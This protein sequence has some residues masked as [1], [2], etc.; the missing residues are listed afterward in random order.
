MGNIKINGD[1]NHVYN[2]IK[3]SSIN[4]NDIAVNSGVNKKWSVWVSII[5]A[6]LTLIATCVIGWDAIIGFFK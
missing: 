5:I 6:A 4:S 2:D 1:N 3:N